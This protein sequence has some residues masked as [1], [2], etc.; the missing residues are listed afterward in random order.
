M[1]AFPLDTLNPRS[2]ATLSHLTLWLTHWIDPDGEQGPVLRFGTG[3]GI[4]HDSEPSGEWAETVLK[5]RTLLA[6]ASR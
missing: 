1:Q 2:L 4:T 5:A 6:V 3:G